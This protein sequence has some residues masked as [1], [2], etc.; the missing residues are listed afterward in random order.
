MQVS[1]VHDKHNDNYG[2]APS[3]TTPKITIWLWP[4]GLFPRRIIYYLCAQNIKLS[5]LRAHN[6][7]LIPVSLDAASVA[8]TTKAGDE[9]PPPGASMPCMRVRSVE[10]EGSD[11]E[12]IQYIHE[13]NAIIAYLEEVFNEGNG[14]NS[15]DGNIL[16]STR[17]QRARTH[18]ITGLLGDAIIYANV[19]LMHSD[20][21]ILSWSGLAAKD[22]SAVTAAHAQNKF[23]RLFFKLEGW[24]EGDIMEKEAPS[25][26]GEG[27]QVTLADIMLMANV[28]Y[29]LDA[30]G[31]NYFDN[32]KHKVLARWVDR[33]SRA[34]W[35][36]GSEALGKAEEAGWGAVLEP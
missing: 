30:F 24:I 1:L 34:A 33:V 35:C 2:M 25:L 31:T 13:S 5:T 6:I 32:E 36:I 9:A 20:I 17:S 21:R 3:A 19:V 16:G 11:S 23:E 18:D 8:F 7:D 4:T 10:G 14:D 22:M 28:T 27:S 29:A 26:S 15:E 12:K